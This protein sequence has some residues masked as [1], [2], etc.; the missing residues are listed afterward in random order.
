MGNFI[1]LV[2]NGISTGLLIALLSGGFSIIFQTSRTFHVAHGAVYVA[3]AYAYWYFAIRG[4]F[5]P[6]LGVV[7][8][9]V[10]AFI[11]AALLGTGCHVWVYQPIKRRRSSFF[12]IFVAS[13]GIT[14]VL[15]N[16]V[17]LLVGTQT[18]TFG[19]SLIDGR[20][21]GGSVFP[22]VDFVAIPVAAVILIG[23][24]VAL[25]RSSVGLLMRALADDSELYR[26]A[27]LKRGRTEIAAF[28]LGSLLVV[29]ASILFGYT[30]GI[31]PNS[32]LTEGTLALA[33]GL[34]GGRRIFS[35][36][37]IA[38]LL[39]GI[40]ESVSTQFVSSDWQ[41]SIGFAVFIVVVLLRPDGLL[42]RYF[43]QR[44]APPEPAEEQALEEPEEVAR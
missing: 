31:T 9:V 17:G 30:K 16:V 15:V 6:V 2:V 37:I 29:P 36:A 44:A 42:P 3:A 28:V 33:A 35:G 27:G 14:T 26:F 40:V 1:V 41:L 8:G 43:R 19:V 39:L 7:L 21:I 23:V 24:A 12:T 10:V 22:T 32:A 25:R 20:K 5:P 4:G 11:I 18:R 13:F 38:G 34:L